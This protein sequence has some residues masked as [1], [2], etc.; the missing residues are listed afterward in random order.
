MKF[1]FL[2]HPITEETRT[3]S[4]FDPTGEARR[5]WG[6]DLRDYCVKMHR[7]VVDAERRAESR[8]SDEVRVIDELTGLVSE[9]GVEARGRLYEIP[10]DAFEILKDTAKAME[11]I[12][13]AVDQA[14]CWGARIAGLGSLTG[15]VGGQGV[16][17][18]EHAHIPVTTGD[19][20]E[21][22]GAL[23]NLDHICEE[24][25]IDLA[26]ET[27]AVVGVPS[28]IAS[29]AARIL[30]HRAGRLIVVSQRPSSRVRKLAEEVGAELSYDIAD[31]LSQ[32]RV[33]FAATS[34]GDCIDQKMLLPGSVVI[35]VAVPTDVR[36]DQMERDDTLILS[37]GLT[38]VPRTMALDSNFLWFHHGMVPSCLAETMTLALEDRAE[39]FSLG[40]NLDENA[41]QEIGRLAVEHGFDFNRMFSFGLP[42]EDAALVRYRKAVAR[43]RGMIQRPKHLLSPSA[44][45][46]T[47][48]IPNAGLPCEPIISGE[49]MVMA[50]FIEPDT[51]PNTSPAPSPEAGQTEQLGHR[52]AKLH[53]RYVDP[54]LIAMGAKSNTTKTF[55]RGEGNYVWDSEGEQYLDFV[56]GNGSLNLG[57]NHPAVVTSLQ[58]TLADAAPGYT[59]GAVNPLAAALAERL[60][61]LAPRGLEMAQFANSGSEAVEAALKLAILAT[62][63]AGLLHLEDSCHGKSLGAL[64][65][66]G[67]PDTRRRLGI[68]A[69]N[70]RSLIPED[71]D[72]LKRRLSTRRYAALIVEPIRLAADLQAVSA[73]YLQAASRL[74]REHGTLLI[75]DESQTGLGRTGKMFAVDGLDVEPD[76]LVLS[77]SLGGG[78]VP[79]GAVLCQ[80]QSWTAAYGT[81]HTSPLA[82]STLAGGS[83]A[84]AAALATLDVIE[85]Q[86]LTAQAAQRGHELVQ[87]MQEICHR[88]KLPLAVHGQGLLLGLE[89]NPLCPTIAAHWREL[90]A[91]KLSPYL[92]PNV[93]AILSGVNALYAM[94][95]LLDGHRIYTQV[96][97][98]SPRLLRI[99]PPLT[100]TREEVSR[101]L[102][103]LDES[104]REYEFATQM[105]GE[106]I[107]KAGLGEHQGSSTPK[108]V[109]TEQNGQAPAMA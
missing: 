39:C 58:Q 94:Q 107:A 88:R 103:T 13:T 59:S 55:V 84:C 93:D 72:D 70:C 87:G 51:L 17:L 66:S 11:Y 102:A 30:T 46:T 108:P 105:A 22:F 61:T 60:V 6:H 24:V 109:K 79:M 95:A 28:G 100:I 63:R 92:I 77:K 40:R 16:Y 47:N 20:L 43:G 52:A 91:T 7:G 90:E 73:E 101:F 2:V 74:C 64:M 49:S 9:Q 34:T 27:V 96:S 54:L 29:A 5:S 98:T 89:F 21:V 75:V 86:T 106:S 36:G 62:G 32:A 18:S 57:H 42:L 14:A 56:A 68:E 97:K 71:L 33:V 50:E 65:V 10:M 37:G 81:V 44:Q 82:D 4:D 41:I 26:E 69:S 23:R 35:D 45:T 8:S 76:V 53:A 104:C 38:R 85:S 48:S 25:E 19:S 1:A 12:E 15:I 99:H 3:L 67:T 78:L 83:L 31:A 80:R